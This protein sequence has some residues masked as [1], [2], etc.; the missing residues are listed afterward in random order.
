VHEPIKNLERNLKWLNAGNLSQIVLS[1]FYLIMLT[2]ALPIEN[3][4]HYSVILG[5]CMV[6][7]SLLD[8]QLH[9]IGSKYLWSLME[10]KGEGH[11]NELG[12]E[13]SALY[14]FELLLKLYPLLLMPLIVFFYTRY[15]DFDDKVSV[16][17]HIAI[18]AYYFL[19]VGSGLTQSILRNINKPHIIVFGVVIELVLR[20]VITLLLILL[21]IFSL[22]SAF[23][24]FF[25]TG[26]LLNL[27]QFAIVH[28]Y[29]KR[30]RIFLSL[31]TMP[32]I[33][34]GLVRSWAMIKTN[35][36]MSWADL[37]S[38]DL[39]VILLPFI[40]VISD[41]SIYKVAKTIS[42]LIWKVMDPIHLALMP[43]ASRWIEE[44]N[45]S[46]V[47]VVIKK[48][49]FY[50]PALCIALALMSQVFLFML[51]PMVQSYGYSGIERLVLIMSLAIIASSFFVYA[52]PCL[53]ALDELKIALYISFATSIIGISLLIILTVKLGIL[54]TAIAWSV[55]FALNLLL[56]GVY[57][58]YR[59]RKNEFGYHEM[60]S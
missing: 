38:K 26:I 30:M 23:G 60:S 40:G 50:A 42:V 33:K 28:Q 20:I 2:V 24:V 14:S 19:R 32:R 54:G 1:A 11:R 31:A 53:V 5:A 49:M 10:I 7:N 48:I 25:V 4:G 39:D 51:S 41:V 6:V 59:L 12:K 9:V 47:M 45:Y 55:A 18:V 44:K 43:E 36:V 52:Y 35:F 3:F 58:H 21:D 57:V 29:L 46:E 37:M 17:F 56:M 22:E 13:I 34:S 16:L 8:P 15:A 27:L